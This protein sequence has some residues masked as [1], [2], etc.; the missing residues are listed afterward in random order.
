MYGTL[1]DSTQPKGVRGVKMEGQ[2][3]RGMASPWK[4]SKT[5]KEEEGIMAS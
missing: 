2:G 5:S 4:A 3:S 1:I